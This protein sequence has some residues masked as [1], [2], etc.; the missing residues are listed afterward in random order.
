M[1]RAKPNG[2]LPRVLFMIFSK[3]ELAEG[4][5]LTSYE[6]RKRFSV[7]IPL[8]LPI[9]HSILQTLPHA[10]LLRVAHIPA[11]GPAI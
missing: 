9:R 2:C 4:G 10:K 11:T 7:P 6:E 8:C 5:L 1:M 3:R